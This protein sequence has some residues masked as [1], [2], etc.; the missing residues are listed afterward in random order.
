MVPLRR[1]VGV[2]SAALVEGVA[3]VVDVIPVG[4]L[5][6]GVL[7]ENHVRCAKVK[8]V[9]HPVRELDHM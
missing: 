7:G 5:G 6:A 1:P 9:F 4:V 8:F 2:L 3:R